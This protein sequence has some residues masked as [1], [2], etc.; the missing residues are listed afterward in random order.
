M[1]VENSFVH[2]TEPDIA[3]LSASDVFIRLD[4]T[5]DGL[6]AQQCSS[7]LSRHGSNTI[8]VEKPIS[9]VSRIRE[10][11]FHT[12]AILLWIAGIAAFI[13]QTPELGVA[14]WSINL[15]NGAFS[16]WQEFHAEKAIEALRKLLPDTVRV[17]RDGRVCSVSSTVLVPGDI[18]DLAE[19]DRISADARLIESEGLQVDQSIL[20]GESR[21]VPKHASA[22]A[23]D[24]NGTSLEAHNL[25]FAGTSVLTGHGRAIV[26]ATGISSQFGHI[27]RLTQTIAE[28]SSP[29][30]KEMARVTR[31]VSIMAT[32]LGAVIFFLAITLTHATLAQAFI[33]SMG[34]VVAFVPEGMLPTVTLSLALA[35]QRMARRKALVKRLSSVETLGC[36]NVICTDKTGTLTQNEM[37]VV[38]AMCGRQHC[39]FSGLGYS[40][41]GVIT[42]MGDDSTGGCSGSSTEPGLENKASVNELLRA[43]LLC[44][45]ASVVFCDGKVRATGDPTEVALIVAA[46]K[47][48]MLKEKEQAL[49]PRLQEIPFDSRR[50]CMTT[51]HRLADQCELDKKIAFVKGS[52]ASIL[53]R[54]SSHLH[55]GQIQ[56]LN[57]EDRRQIIEKI[58]ACASD[59]LRVIAIAKKALDDPM[60]CVDGLEESL[61]FLGFFGMFDPPHPEVPAAVQQCHD[62]G[63]QVV[64]IT[65][66]YE[67]TAEAIAR[68]VGIVKEGAVR[69]ITGKQLDRIADQELVELLCKQVIFARVNPEHKLRIVQA[70]QR[71]G[72]I[73]AVTGDGVNDAPALKRADIGV[74]MGKAGTDV[75]REAADMIL[76]DDN[77]A[78]IVNAVE[79]GRAVYDNIKKFAVYVF[80]SNMAEAVPFVVMLLS[81]GMIPLPLTI[82][83]VLS[84]DLGTD[85]MPAIGLGADPAEEGAMSRPPRMLSQPLLSR[86]LLV[87]ALLWYGMIESVAGMSGYFFHNYLNGWPGKALAVQGSDVWR[88]ATTMTL[89]CIVAAQIGAVFCC[90]TEQRSIFS[91]NIFDNRLITAGIVV[92]VL[93]LACLIY[94]APFQKVFNTAPLGSADLLFASMWIL[95]MI[96]L[97]EVR[98][99]VLRNRSENKFCTGN[100]IDLSV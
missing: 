44:N 14:I 28:Q 75:A 10:N 85:M 70:F 88:A 100:R 49:F 41:D 29:L 55:N 32:S 61:T 74:A 65:G 12:M 62:A 97:D 24:R 1:N 42:S 76:L 69:V 72:K 73:V 19:G 3:G 80:N 81:C 86:Q 37:T 35:V 6:D 52:P 47:A 56:Q 22:S 57:G 48:G 4:T 38:R 50:K 39:S 79:E 25:V 2:H 59:G 51:V 7:R 60:V 23:L 78:S 18:L 53:E 71:A 58:D 36:T 83:Q 8:T 27:A 77:F 93:L 89:T 64:M 30:Q 94:F 99:I 34:M 84:I 21:P 40:F 95:V 5:P 31:R 63:I 20:T 46:A 43:G 90:R 91:Q 16:F 13:A 87:K 17:I 33:F 45:N 82:M 11:F 66:D 15:I 9:L 98:K 26:Y 68:K 92:E 54:C 96:A 67:V